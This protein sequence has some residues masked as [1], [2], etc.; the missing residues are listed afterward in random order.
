VIYK[1]LVQSA[2]GLKKKTYF[3]G[4]GLLSPAAAL[5]PFLASSLLAH[6]EDLGPSDKGLE[7]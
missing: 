5:T 1:G 6:L 2:E 3:P 4:D 7:I